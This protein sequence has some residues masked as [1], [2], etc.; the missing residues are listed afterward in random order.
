MHEC[1]NSRGILLVDCMGKTLRKTVR[2]C[3]VGD[4][5]QYFHETQQGGLPGRG[6]DLAA[7]SLRLFIEAAFHHKRSAGVLFV[8]LVSAFY[9]VVRELCMTLSTSDE[10]IAKLFS[11]LGLP[12]SAM[13]EL[14]QKLQ[15][16]PILDEAGVDPHLRAIVS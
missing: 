7:H 11:T 8:D 10:D 6:T 14:A 5:G 3:L 12:P 15:E 4:A 9:T 1:D 16:M 2:Q 13:H